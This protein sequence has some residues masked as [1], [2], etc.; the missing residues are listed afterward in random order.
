[1]NL[2]QTSCPFFVKFNLKI[3]KCIECLECITKT[4]NKQSDIAINIKATKSYDKPLGKL[5]FHLIMT[6]NKYIFHDN[7]DPLSFAT[8]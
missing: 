3:V 1:M 5:S 6:K 8:L 2:L 4:S 7:S